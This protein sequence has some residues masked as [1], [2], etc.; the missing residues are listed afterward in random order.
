MQSRGFQRGLP[1]TSSELKHDMENS[2]EL[3]TKSL[4]LG[5][6]HEKQLL[7]GWRVSFGVDGDVE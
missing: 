4:S 3:L 2:R 7:S 1:K 5:M 6:R